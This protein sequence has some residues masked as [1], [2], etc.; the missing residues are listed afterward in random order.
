MSVKYDFYPTPLRKFEK[1]EKYH[2]RMLVKHN[3]STG[4][5]ADKIAKRSTMHQSDVIGVLRAL[6]DVVTEELKNGNRVKIDGLGSFRIKIKAP[7]VNQLGIIRSES[8][9]Y[10]GIVYKA[11]KELGNELKKTG[12]EKVPSGQVPHSK[13][14]SAAEIELAMTSFFQTH[15]FITTRDLA[16]LCGLARTTAHR[17]LLALVEEGKLTHPGPR[18]SGE[19]FPVKEFFGK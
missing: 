11:D 18:N 6:Q 14:V 2:V 13:K 4:E 10:D 16:Y 12:F 8:I 5:L 17:R 15:K 1:Q 3:I 19:Y 9:K 7:T